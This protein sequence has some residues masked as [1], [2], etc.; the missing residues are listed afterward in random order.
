MLV[1][2]AVADYVELVGAG[3]FDSLLFEADLDA[4]AQFATD[5]VLLAG[6]GLH[7]KEIVHAFSGDS[8]DSR[9]LR[10]GD[11]GVEVMWV[12]TN[13][14]G[15]FLQERDH[16]IAVFLVIHGNVHG[17]LRPIPGEI[18]DDGHLTVGDHVDGAV[19]IAKHSA[20]E[21]QG[22]YRALDSGG[23]DDVSDVKGVLYEDEESVDEVFD[24]GLGAEA[25]GKTDDTGGG[26][27]RP[28]VQPEDGQDRHGRIENDHEDPNAVDDTGQR[29]E[30]LSAKPGGKV[31]PLTVVDE[32]IPECSNGQEDDNAN[33]E[34]AENL[35]CV[36][37]Q[38]VNGVLAPAVEQ[39][40]PVVVRAYGNE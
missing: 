2:A 37:P 39:V 10:F 7:N 6:S 21:G 25:D 19:G 12:V 29:A 5:C 32:A 18:T 40:D 38:E 31:L 30:L 16:T 28:D 22:F 4:T 14:G 11:D 24:Q 35:G 34:N 13:F 8:V 3:G 23:A 36:M 9:N 27:E 1:A 17:E 26:E 33:D 20:A 15:D